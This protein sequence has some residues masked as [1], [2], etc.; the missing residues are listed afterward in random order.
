MANAGFMSMKWL[1][2]HIKEIIWA[3]VILFVGSIFVIGYGTSRAIQNQ[4]ERQKMADEAERRAAAQKHA[5]PNHLQD[6]LHLPVAHISFPTSTASL[7]TVIDVKSLWRAVKDSPEFQQ[8]SNMPAG[9]REFYGSMIK[10]KALEGLITLTLVDLYAQANNIKPQ[11]TKEALVERDRQQITPVEFDRELRRKGVSPDEWGTDRLRQ[12]TMQAVAQNVV[13]PIP[14]ASATEEVLK[15]YYEKNKNRFRE[16]DQLTFN[17]LLVSSDDFA[18]KTEIT[19]EQIKTHFDSHRGDF[20]SSARVQVS[21]IIIKPQD[22][23]YLAAIEVN[24]REIRRRY[25]DNL[26]KYKEPEKVRARHILIKPKNTFD[27]EFAG[28][29]A[30][31]RNFAVSENEGGAVLTF[32][33]G[34]ANLGPDTSLNFD[35]FAVKTS[36]GKLYYP[37]ISSQEKAENALELPL[38]GSTKNAVFGKIAIDIEKGSQ[39]VEL[40]IKDGAVTASIDISSA[41]DGEKAFAAARAEIEAIAEQIKGGKDFN[42]LATSKSQDT[43]SAVKGG[44]LG[45]FARGAMV[46]PFE[47]IAFSSNV[48]QVSEPVRTQFG[49]HLIKVEE[50]IPEKVRSLD[51]VR[52]ELIKEY[53]QQQAD[54]KAAAAME[55]IRQKL[56]YKSDTLENQVKM[57]MGASRKNKGDLPIFFKGEITDDYSPEQKKILLDEI[58]ADGSSVAA[59]I[60][61]A[62]FS[63]EPGQVSDVIRTEKGY[64]LFVLNKILEPVQLT[65]TASLKTRIHKILEEKAKEE[66]ARL[67]AEKLKKDYPDAGIEFI[68]KNY[69][70]EV[71]DVKFNF[72]PL[73]FSANPG[74]SSYSLSDGM[75]RF[76]E[77]GRTYLPEVHKTVMTLIKDGNFKGKIAGPFKSALGYHFIEVTEYV[78]NRYQPYEEVKEKIRRWLTLEPSQEELEKAFEENRDQFDR[79]ATRRIRQ[80]IVSEERSANDLH[81]RLKKGEIFALLAQ[82]FSMDTGSAQQGGLVPPVKKGQ[83]SGELDKQVWSLKKGEFTPPVKTSYGYVIALLDADEIPGKQATLDADV[84]TQLKR[85]LR[86]DIQEEVWMSFLKSLNFQAHVIR[87]PQAMAEI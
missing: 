46:K 33:A 20:M 21:H 71:E 17:H 68:A 82:K 44:D 7:T 13:K 49:Y 15:E 62:V 43:G 50:K 52:A 29:K 9:I 3:T 48:G 75:G 69:K 30:N 1:R 11:I 86:Q 10:E 5:V 6:K 28:Y 79:P 55:N 65:L 24:D 27:H 38:S 63:M 70:P 74:F 25:T 77:D 16:D 23:Q 87:H 19:D 34:L 83:L 18:G 85:K 47:E 76:T 22:Q 58:S 42:E 4:E 14:P 12:V 31:L 56:L 64:H 53:Q 67:A 2:L 41:F 32:D 36:D 39:P 35:T 54:A 80:I 40:S 72:G 84:T 66:M 51:E 57:S 8:V 78:G 45:A 81:E 37:T 26:D 59:E 73:P 61:E 60:E